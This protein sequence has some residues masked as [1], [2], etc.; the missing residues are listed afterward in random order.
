MRNKR[1]EKGEFKEVMP[2]SQ[3]EVEAGTSWLQH[4]H[5]STHRRREEDYPEAAL[6]HP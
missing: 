4:T 3:A 5:T 6:H 1:K 2:W